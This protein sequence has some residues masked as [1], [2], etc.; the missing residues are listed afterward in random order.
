MTTHDYKIP[1]SLS[2]LWR[3]SQEL[4][5][6]EH[7]EKEIAEFTALEER[8]CGDEAEN[9]SDL[10]AKLQYLHIRKEV[11]WND[12]SERLYQSIVDGYKNLVVEKQDAWTRLENAIVNIRGAANCL[13]EVSLEAEEPSNKIGTYLGERLL[14]HA[15]TIDAVFNELHRAHVTDLERLVPPPKPKDAQRDLAKL[16]VA[17]LGPRA[18]VGEVEGVRKALS[19][20]LAALPAPLCEAP[21]TA[22]AGA[23]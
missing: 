19:F 21:V 9:T 11:E 1:M 16:M 4:E 13:L 12:K 10:L 5:E 14:E 3:R 6:V 22:E 18:T 17:A 7:G 23:S 2:A 8:L 20:M 15:G